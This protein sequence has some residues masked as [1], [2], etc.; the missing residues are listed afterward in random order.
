MLC[1]IFFLITMDNIIK[2]VRSKVKKLIVGYRDIKVVELMVDDLAIFA[3]SKR[4][5]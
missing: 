5:L 2:E 1:L 4:E 3:R